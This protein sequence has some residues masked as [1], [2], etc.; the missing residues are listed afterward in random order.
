MLAE[1]TERD[2]AGDIAAIYGEIRRL[3]AVPY[4]SSLERHLATRAGWLEWV[5]A[6]V[7]PAFT[8]GRAQTAA[9]RAVE[10]LDVPRLAPVTRDALRVWG[11]D[12]DGE[13]AMGAVC[14]S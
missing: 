11:V 12:A 1:L 14:A 6:A 13:A 9:W 3:W 8:S 10:Q 7:G 2:A 5:W 4:V